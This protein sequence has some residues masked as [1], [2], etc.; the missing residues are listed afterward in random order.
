MLQKSKN[1]A[2]KMN[3][4]IIS[5][6]SVSRVLTNKIVPLYLIKDAT[7]SIKH[8]EFLSIV[9]PSGSGKSSLLY[10]MGLLDSPSSGEIY[11]D[12]MNVNFMNVNEKAALRLEKIGFIFQFHFL[13]PEFTALENVLLPIRKLGYLT[14]KIA[15]ERASMLLENFKLPIDKKPGEMSGGECQRVAIARALA[16]NPTLI[17]ADEPTGSLDTKNAALVFQSLERLS[18]E[19][20]KTIVIVTHDQNISNKTNRSIRV[21][22]GKIHM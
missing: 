21:V 10:L 18:Q 9:G 22:D 8:G 14:N 3:S 15:L 7:F 4:T 12:E 11:I 20:G 2:T 16:N 17:L 1:I 19:Q 13:I 6:H 5:F